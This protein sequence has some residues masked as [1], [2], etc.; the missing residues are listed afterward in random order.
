MR[1]K[2][3]GLSESEAKLRLKKF[4]L[5]KLPEVAPP[6]DLSILISQ[7]K[8][9]LIYILLFAGIVT[10]MLRDYTDATVISFAVVINTVLGF[11]QERRASKAL[12]ALKALIHPIAVVVRD[13]ERMKIE[14][15]SIVPDDVCILNT[16]DKIPADGKIL[17]A[18]HLF[19]SEAILTGESVPVGKEKNDKAFMGTVVTA[20]N[21]ILLVETTGEETEIGKIALQVQE[22]YEDTP[23]KRQLVNFSRQ[24]T[25]LVFSLTAF[26]FIVGLVSGREL[27]EIFTT[28][29]A[30]AVS[31]IPEG[32]LVGL[33]VVLAIGMQKIL[34]QKGLVRN[35]VSAE[36]LGGVTTICIDKTG[37]LTEGHMQVVDAIGNEDDLS[38]QSIIANDLDDPLV[39]AAYERGL[40]K[41]KIEDVKKKYERL[42]S[43][44]FTSENRF[45]TSLNKWDKQSNMLF[46]NGAPE[47]LIEWSD[48]DSERSK[49]IR[50]KI[51][52]L[53]SKGK[54]LVGIARKKVSMQKS[55]L[56]VQ[57]VKNNLEWVGLLAFSDP[58][59]EGVYESLDKTKI[60]GIKLLVITGDYPQTALS[61]MKSLNIEPDANSIIRGDELEKMTTSELSQR[62]LTIK[63][64]GLFAR[65][66]PEQKFKIVESLKG[67]GEVVA[68]MGDGVNDAP[69][70]KQ[71]DIGIVV[72][73]ASDVAKE[74]ADLVLLDSS[75]ATIIAAIEE[76]RSIFDNIRKV[77]LYLMSDAFEEIIAVVG[78]LFLKLPLPVSAAQIL[79]INLVSDGFPDLALT[80]DP[81]TRGIMRRNPRNGSENLVAPWMKTLIFIVSLVG[82]IF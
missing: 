49:A 12:L 45:F 3:S 18:N 46:V 7:F 82:G 2:S 23:L 65:T 62:L 61:V 20:G 39:I 44:P 42:D 73:E 6:S 56:S 55:G 69:A 25:I 21:G 27:L 63:H 59:R 68:M 41:I 66:T 58:V 53:T 32:L 10:L 75:F 4:G 14:V 22:P 37:T 36:T 29:V 11:F 34:K 70:L 60:A 80:L 38:L 74:S 57:D 78:S 30:L 71:A 54:R 24:L 40:E 77:I 81:K 72:G 15:E 8:S 67:N 43:I 9:P 64:S 52:V 28:S 50:D 5:N 19:I 79:W 31:S 48:L 76:G 13:G 16:G 1:L 47:F 17:S 51:E 35:L 26:V 33:T